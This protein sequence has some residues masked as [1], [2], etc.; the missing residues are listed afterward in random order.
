MAPTWTG[1]GLFSEA[2]CSWVME[3]WLQHSVCTG[4]VR[5]SL[6][7]TFLSL[8]QV[9]TSLAVWSMTENNAVAVVACYEEIVSERAPTYSAHSASTELG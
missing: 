6:N 3:S 9:I 7:S 8:K 1:P 5:I 4:V 2:V